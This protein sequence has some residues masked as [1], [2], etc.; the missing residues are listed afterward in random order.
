M[1]EIY[2]YEPCTSDISIAYGSSPSD[3]DVRKIIPHGDPFHGSATSHWY[4]TRCSVTPESKSSESE[5]RND[6]LAVLCL[7]LT[8]RIQLYDGK[9]ALCEDAAA[10]HNATKRLAENEIEHGLDGF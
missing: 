5:R 1:K 3:A 9:H 6:F 4:T 10:G 8:S 7:H 2:F